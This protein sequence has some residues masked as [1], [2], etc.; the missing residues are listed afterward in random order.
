MRDV[1]TKKFIE[2]CKE[3]FK[4]ME[5]IKPPE[6]SRFAKTGISRELPPV[7][8]D[9]WYTRAASIF[10]RICLDG[11]VGVQR[12]RTYYGGRKHRGHKP[13]RFRRSGGSIV[14]KCLQQLEATGLIEKSKNSKKRG[15]IVSEAGKK[16][17]KKI[18][19]EAKK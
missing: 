14:R 16:F 10:R 1:D 2:V 8:E 12:L 9:W 3:E 6:W 13:E 5:K 15:R 17:L 7:Q 4:K 19:P 18:I 11:P